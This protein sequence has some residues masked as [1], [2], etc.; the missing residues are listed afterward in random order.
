MLSNL[1][2]PPRLVMYFFIG[3]IQHECPKNGWR[4]Q[5]QA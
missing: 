1:L 4:N 5:R 2:C 3:S